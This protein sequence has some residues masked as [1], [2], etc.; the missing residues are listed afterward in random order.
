MN[1]SMIGKIE[2]AR[3]YAQEPERIRINA[4]TALFHGTNDDYTVNLHDGVWHCSC[5]T[6]E[7][8]GSCAH[9]IAA[10]RLL[11]PMLPEMARY[12]RTSWTVDPGS[13][14]AGKL[15]K[16]RR[17]TA[18]PERIALGLFDATF[19]G[20]N[21]DHS[22]TLA[23]GSWH[24]AC[25]FFEQHSSCAHVMAA[26]RLLAPMLPETARYEATATLAAATA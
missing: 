11:A 16:A 8:F 24:C 4:L 20:S 5:H 21:D 6:F 2:K 9:I 13:S 12:E 26:Q 25:H 17:Y 19:R 23:N 3:R 14:L 10:Q 1:S 15:E 7:H 22:L 18:E